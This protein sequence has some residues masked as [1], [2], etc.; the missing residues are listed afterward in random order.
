LLD[1]LLQERISWREKKFWIYKTGLKSQQSFHFRFLPIIFKKILWLHCLIHSI[2][3][4]LVYSSPRQ[5]RVNPCL[6]SAEP[7]PGSKSTKNKGSCISRLFFKTFGAFGFRENFNLHMPRTS[8]LFIDMHTSYIKGALSYESYWKLL[9]CHLLTV[10]K[11]FCF[12][13]DTYF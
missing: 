2:K 10:R 6:W 4:S 7:W 9:V 8:S 11:S 5:E 12:K 1:S 13:T 3:G